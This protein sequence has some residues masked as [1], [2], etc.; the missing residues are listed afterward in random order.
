[1][2]AHELTHGVTQYESNL[3]YYYQSGAINESLSDVFG[4]LI[5]LEHPAT[6]TDTAANR[7]LMGEDLPIGAIRDMENPPTFGDPDRM[8]LADYFHTAASDNGGVHINSG[9][10]NKAAFLMTDGGTFNGQTITGARRHQ[11][12]PHLLRGPGE[13]AHLGQRL[14]R[15]RQHACRQACTNL[16]GTDGITAANCTEVSK[17]VLATEMIVPAPANDNLAAAIELTPT[18]GTTTGSTTGATRQANENAPANRSERIDLVQVHRRQQRHGRHRHLRQQLRHAARRLH[19]L[20]VPLDA[21][22]H[23]R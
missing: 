12:R 8:E 1:M 4:E 6:G 10:N 13:P 22:H 20:G 11:G 2:V 19:R 18:T 21:D 3:V 5:D 14:R 9:V 16:I 7:W 17:A 23:E 15:P